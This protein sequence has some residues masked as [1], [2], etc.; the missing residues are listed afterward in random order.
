MRRLV[1]L[2]A[3]VVLAA[4]PASGQEYGVPPATPSPTPGYAL[5]TVTP[6]P[7]PS[8]AAT[9][10]RTT[11]AIRRIRFSKTLFPNVR[12]HYRVATGRGWPK[13]LVLNRKGAAARTRKVLAKVKS[14]AGYDRD[15]YPPAIGRGRGKGLRQG[16][17]PRGWVADV[18]YVR[19]PEGVVATLATAVKLARYCDGTRF[20]YAFSK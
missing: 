10:C 6:S 11:K 2:T 3:L 14:K 20:R 12:K 15:E 16:R 8:P 9:P 18:G 17:K 5:P 19:S 13:V 4:V 7:S 1:M